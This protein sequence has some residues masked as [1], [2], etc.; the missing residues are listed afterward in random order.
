MEV[1]GTPRLITKLPAKGILSQVLRV[2]PSDGLPRPRNKSTSAAK[3][4]DAGRAQRRHGDTTDAANNSPT[5]TSRRP[6]RPQ[7]APPPATGRPIR[8]RPLPLR[9]LTERSRHN[10]HRSRQRARRERN[11]NRA[12]ASDAGRRTAVGPP[13][14]RNREP[15]GFG[16]HTPKGAI[17]SGRRWGGAR[18]GGWTAAAFRPGLNRRRGSSTGG[19]SAHDVPG[20]GPSQGSS[21]FLV[22]DPQRTA[23]GCSGPGWP[24]REATSRSSHQKR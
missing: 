4:A 8:A 18:A 15:A 12:R 14:A 17:T 1:R 16:D 11:G 5:T 9:Q 2:I 10:E 19:L 24:H 13:A 21:G 7:N 6:A 3:Y 20:P 22:P 23:R